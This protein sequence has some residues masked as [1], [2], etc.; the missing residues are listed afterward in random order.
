MSGTVDARIK[1]KRGTTA[2]WNAARGFI[3]LDGELI[4]YTNYKTIQKEINGELQIVDVPGVKIGDG[5]T[6]VQDLPFV[7]EELRSRIMAHIN[8]P[9]VHVS[10]QEKLFW[11]NKLNVDD[12]AELVDGALIFNRN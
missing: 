7:D 3:P 8:N 12:N 4:V 10:T 2:N 1:H 6:Y 9:D 5:R 11:S